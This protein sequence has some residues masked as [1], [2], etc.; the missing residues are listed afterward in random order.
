MIADA[1]EPPRVFLLHSTQ[2]SW[3]ILV[4]DILLS[5]LIIAIILRIFSEMLVQAFLA[6]EV[7]EYVVIMLIL[8]RLSADIAHWQPIELRFSVCIIAVIVSFGIV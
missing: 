5:V 2:S 8:D 4:V 6:E 3:L 7:A 1:S